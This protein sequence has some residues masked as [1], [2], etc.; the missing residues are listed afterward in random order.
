MSPLWQQG[1]RKTS[2]SQN[3]IGSEH[4]VHLLPAR[5]GSGQCNHGVGGGSRDTPVVFK[6]KEGAC[7]ACR[8]TKRKHS[9]NV[10]LWYVFLSLLSL[11]EKCVLRLATAIIFPVRITNY[12]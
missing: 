6:E 1:E 3:T 5:R 10:V 9:D 4:R 2:L 11:A 7:T 12:Y 8:Q